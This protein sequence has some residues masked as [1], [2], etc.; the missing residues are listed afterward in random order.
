MSS[1]VCV[2]VAK[3]VYAQLKKNLPCSVDAKEKGALKVL[4]IVA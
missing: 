4:S 2:V 3:K 1:D